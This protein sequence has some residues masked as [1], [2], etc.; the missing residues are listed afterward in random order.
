MRHKI[1]ISIMSL[2]LFMLSSSLLPAQETQEQ[3]GSVVAVR[4]NATAFD[5]QGNTRTLAMKS[6]VF[7]N[8]ILKTGTKGRIQVLFTDNTIV[9]IGRASEIEISEYYWM[10]NEKTGAMKTRVKEGVFRVMG[11]AITR[12]SPQNFTTETPAATIGIRGSMYAGKVADGQLVVVFEGGK[13]IDVMNNAGSVAI[14]KAGFGTRIASADTPPETPKRFSAQDIS[15]L[16]ENMNTDSGQDE[17]EEE[18]APEEESKDEEAGD[19]DS[20]GDQEETSDT[21]D[22]TEQDS[23]DDTA[24]NEDAAA[25]DEDAST[26]SDDPDDSGQTPDEGDGVTE[27]SE[28]TAVETAG[29]TG[30]T[31]AGTL[32]TATDTGGETD[33]A[34]TSSDFTQDDSSFDESF[35]ADTDLSQDT[36]STADPMDTSF[37]EVLQEV[38]ETTTSASQDTL[39]NT[40]NETSQSGITIEGAFLAG[41][42]AD[43]TQTDFTRWHGP[44]DATSINGSVTSTAASSFDFSF[45]M[46]PYNP[47]AMYIPPFTA[48]EDPIVTVQSRTVSLAGV[49]RTFDSGVLSSNLGEFAIFVIKDGTFTANSTLYGYQDM[50]FAGIPSPASSAPATGIWSYIGPSLGFDTYPLPPG[51]TLEINTEMSGMWLEVNWLSGKFVGR[52]DFDP[53][54]EVPMEEPGPGGKAFIFGD[55][56]GT[57][58]TNMKLCGYGGPGDTEPSSIIWVEG[59]DGQAQ[60]YGSQ[61]QGIGITGTAS[62]YDIE[63]D[64]N[65]TVG[66]GRMIAAGFKKEIDYGD[67]VS[68]TGTSLYSG[69]VAGIAEDMN[70]ITTNRKLF[71]NYDPSEFSFTINRNTGTISGTLY[72]SDQ[73]SGTCYL[74]NLEIGGSFGSAYVLDD[75]FVAMLGDTDSESIYYSETIK[76][77]LKSYGNYMITAN[78]DER[79]SE[80]VS[81]GYWEI[82]YVDPESSGQYHLHLPG[83]FW[84]AGEL[85]PSSVISDLVTNNITGTYTGGAKGVCIN[86][87]SE[88]S[89]LTNGTSDITVNFGT[90]QV[91]GD[92]TFD[93]VGLTLTGGML[94]ASNSSFFSEISGA[95]SS[96]VNGAFYGPNANSVGGN[97]N[98]DFTS[99]AGSTR[100]MGIFGG[101]RVP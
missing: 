33:T 42:N 99:G 19:D 87:A 73:L 82:S 57:T 80:Y 48:T 46:N 47:D 75:N 52:M 24:D 40:V 37:T 1:F 64:Q 20:T 61:C 67:E 9:S 41:V 35:S 66:A 84:I 51:E 88:I 94:S 100:Y 18:N 95:T 5:K 15:D 13:G 92:I 34:A 3:V 96:S 68:P 53:E 58:L 91:T 10:P 12:E 50:G 44:V 31:E 22:E 38:T 54:P 14:T 77:G 4:G 79:F 101:N 32:D 74:D 69:F 49:N 30:N 21:T 76:G 25:T 16:N 7:K 29:D 8:D 2:S 39:D 78:P 71:M 81:W 11:G 28:D 86:T 17:Q 89:E 26:Q 93:E 23:G 36:T 43:G 98:A 85:T 55:I 59:T 90:Y 70:N 56:S 97:F 65:A 60:F 27:T 83:D 72:A 62:F 63:S 6:P 45:S